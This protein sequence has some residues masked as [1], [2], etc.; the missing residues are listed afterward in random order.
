MFFKTALNNETK[1]AR[2]LQHLALLSASRF[3]SALCSGDTVCKR[4]KY[5]RSG[6]FR[7]YLYLAYGDESRTQK[8]KIKKKSTRQKYYTK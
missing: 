1:N 3:Q 5:N 8:I 7:L 6:W 2:W 4:A